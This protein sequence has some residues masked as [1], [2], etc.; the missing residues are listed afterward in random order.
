M[1]NIKIKKK[2]RLCNSL[3][4]S[5]VFNLCKSPLANN[6][7]LSQKS[8]INA[9]IYP[10]NLMFCNNCK[11]VQLQHVVNPKCLFD[12]YLYMTGISNQFKIHFNKYSKVAL[13]KFN[14]T[15]NIKVLEIGS[16][17]CTLLDYFKKYKCLTVGIEPAKNLFEITKNNHHIINSYYNYQTNKILKKKI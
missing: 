5:K 11:H 10:L 17:D 8:S 3:K 15:K 1:K 4:L 2:C 16:N 6:L 7:A 13:N 14:Y 9:K 12:K